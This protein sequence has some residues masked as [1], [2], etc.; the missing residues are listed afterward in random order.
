MKIAK[1]PKL[2]F[3]AGFALI[4]WTRSYMSLKWLLMA[5]VNLALRLFWANLSFLSLNLLS[6]C[7]KDDFFRSSRELSSDKFFTG[8]KLSKEESKM[9]SQSFLFWSFWFSYMSLEIFSFWDEI[10]FFRFSIVLFS[11]KF[12]YDLN[13]YLNSYLETLGYKGGSKETIESFRIYLV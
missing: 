11:A 12:I 3:L 10:L 5:A 9:L 8:D 7:S 1:T 4:S 2:I 13:H 6:L